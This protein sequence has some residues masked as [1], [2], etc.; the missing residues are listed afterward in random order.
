MVFDYL[1]IFLIISAEDS[2]GNLSL[3][4][5]PIMVSDDSSISSP[6]IQTQPNPPDV[7]PTNKNPISMQLDG[8]FKLKI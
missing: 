7:L 5:G 6:N 4:E 1:S 3:S 8:K 2:F